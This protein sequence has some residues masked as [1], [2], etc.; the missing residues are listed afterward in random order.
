M[1]KNK[2]E[3]NFLPA[4][5]KMG[6]WRFSSLLAPV[7]DKFK[8]FLGEGNTS[9]DDLE[10]L[11]VII[12]RE[13]KNPT[14]SLK[15]RGMVYLISKLYSQGKRQFVLSSSGN[16]AI[17]ALTLC[18]TANLEIKLFVSPNIEEGKLFRLR[19]MKGDI[20][21]T[22]KPLSGAAKY[23]LDY[24]YHNLRPSLNDFGREGY[25]TIAFE[26]A[27]KRGVI[28]DI[29]LP[30]SSGV[31]LLGIHEG[32]KKIGYMPR[33]HACQSSKI[34]MIS[35]VYDRNFKSEEISLAKALVARSVPLKERILKAI[36]ESK[37]FGWVINNQEIVQ[38]QEILIKKGI[39]TSNEGS[40]ALAAVLKARNQG[41]MLGKTICLLTGR[42]Y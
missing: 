32:F 6:I 20:T 40:L 4:K 35:A 12:K 13:D 29:F 9:L 7:E 28:D 31:S 15:D 24:Q 3:F 19:E 33:I 23:A 16:A 5:E 36:N 27:D 8:L 25:Q 26:I 41:W 39:E 14:G 10:D 17:S 30:V 1:R 37:G 11:G 38:V 21:V 22:P 42:K 18:Q 34:N 2:I